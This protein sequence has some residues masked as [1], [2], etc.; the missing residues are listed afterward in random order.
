MAGLMLITSGTILWVRLG[1][2]E[3][4]FWAPLLY[5]VVVLG[6]IEASYF[7]FAPYLPLVNPTSLDLLLY[8]SDLQLFGFESAVALAPFV[9]PLGSEWFAFFYF[10]Y[11][12]LL[13]LHLVPVTLASQRDRLRGEVTFGFMTLFCV[14]QL[15]YLMVPG[16]GPFRAIPQDLPTHFPPGLW[17]DTVM[18]AVAKGGA[19]K[20]IFPSLHTAAPTFFALLSFRHRATLPFRDTWW[21][22]SAFTLNIVVATMYLRWHWLIDVV[23]GLTLA[24]V[25]FGLCVVVTDWELRR[26][27]RLGLAPAW[28]HLE[29]P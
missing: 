10:C 19:Q 27:E 8:R 24:G 26:R 13:T 23:A 25:G 4:G 14:G 11:F 5:R 21:I 18:T 3:S 20:D 6:S 12:V 9:G 7:F 16:F 22:M 29:K 2:I 1:R 17:L 28:L 15:V